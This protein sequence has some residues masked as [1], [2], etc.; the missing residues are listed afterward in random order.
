M[1]WW[2]IFLIALSIIVLYNFAINTY[3]LKRIVFIHDDYKNWLAGNSDTFVENSAEAI[4]LFEKSGQRDSYIPILESAGYGQ[5]RS[6]NVSVFAN[7]SNRREEVIPIILDYFSKAAG[8]FKR[9]RRDSLNPLCWV[10]VVV[11]LPKHIASYFNAKPESV[12]TKIFQVIWWFLAPLAILFRDNI[13][14]FLTSL[15]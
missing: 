15:F 12:Y 13:Y 14:N 5:L 8:I 6:M 10:E 9:K 7:L 11:F 2:G 4:S 3:R 1:T